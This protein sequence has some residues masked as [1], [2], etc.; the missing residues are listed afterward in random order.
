MQKTAICIALQIWCAMMI[1]HVPWWI[2]P[3]LAILDHV[4]WTQLDLDDGHFFSMMG[5][6]Y[7]FLRHHCH[8]WF[9]IGLMINNLTIAIELFFTAEPFNGDGFSMVFQILSMMVINGL[10]HGIR[11]K[12]LQFTLLFPQQFTCSGYFGI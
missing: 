9:S 4:W 10:D 6:W 12:L 7:F 3:L 8:R 5:W 2:C 11:V 1:V